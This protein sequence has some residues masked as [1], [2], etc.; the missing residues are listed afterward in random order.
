MLHTVYFLISPRAELISRIHGMRQAGTGQ[1][2]TVEL[3]LKRRH[4]HPLK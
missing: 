2:Q 4:E 1:L 3:S